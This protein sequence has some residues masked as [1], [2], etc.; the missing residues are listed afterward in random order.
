MLCG[1]D[2]AFRQADVTRE[3]S[4]FFAATEQS[5]FCFSTGNE[6]IL[7]LSEVTSEAADIVGLTHHAQPSGTIVQTSLAQLPGDPL[8]VRCLQSFDHEDN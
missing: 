1:N 8:E 3:E 2:L 5:S 4:D 6:T 7:N